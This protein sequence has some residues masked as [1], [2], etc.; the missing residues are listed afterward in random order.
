MQF[1]GVVQLPAARV[2]QQVLDNLKNASE[3]APLDVIQF[4]EGIH[5]IH[6]GDTDE[7][8]TDNLATSIL[9]HMQLELPK[10]MI[11]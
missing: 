9:R 2:P 4:L 10:Q 5:D 8:H 7:T 1:F 3:D 6:A 11:Q